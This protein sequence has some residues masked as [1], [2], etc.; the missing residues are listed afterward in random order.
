MA[1]PSLVHIGGTIT[2]STSV[3]FFADIRPNF[4]KISETR[5]LNQLKLTDYG[6]EGLYSPLEA[7]S[8]LTGVTQMLSLLG[9][10]INRFC[11]KFLFQQIVQIKDFIYQDFGSAN[12]FLILYSR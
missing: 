12:F 1:R 2:K 11:I 3:C 4:P 10:D 7:P 9:S 8:I 5:D 6:I